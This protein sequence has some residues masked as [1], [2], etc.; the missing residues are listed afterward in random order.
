M[1]C[2]CVRAWGSR[3]GGSDDDV[4][5]AKTATMTVAGGGLPLF[6]VKWPDGHFTTGQGGPKSA[7][8][9]LSDG[10]LERGVEDALAQICRQN[11]KMGGKRGGG[12]FRARG[13]E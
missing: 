2:G 7:N 1:A 12:G 4:R 10:Y 6:M 3:G 9:E 8:S 13:V 11:K 5:A